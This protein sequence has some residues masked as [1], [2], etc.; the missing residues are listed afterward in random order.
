[1]IQIF[2]VWQD[3]LVNAPKFLCEWLDMFLGADSNDQS[4]TSY[5]P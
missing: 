1:M 2:K 3:D 4:Q 5:Q